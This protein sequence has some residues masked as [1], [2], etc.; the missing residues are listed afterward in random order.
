MITMNQY[1]LFVSDFTNLRGGISSG[2]DNI[3]FSFHTGLR[4][5]FITRVF[6]DCSMRRTLVLVTRSTI[7]PT[8]VRD[9]EKSSAEWF[10]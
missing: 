8:A 1:H 9:H 7:N 2:I 4:L 6:I 10:T 5:F 3:S